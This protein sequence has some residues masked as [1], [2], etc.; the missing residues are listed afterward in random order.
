[1]KKVAIIG[2]CQ[3]RP[4]ANLL[5]AVVPDVKFVALTAV[6]RIDEHEVQNFLSSLDSFDV[7]ITQP[8]ATGYRKNIGIDTEKLRSRM[9]ANQRL[10]LIPNLYFEGFF[11]TWGYMK[12][13]QSNLRG[14]MPPGILPSRASEGIFATL[15]K[16]DYQCFFLLCAWLSGISAQTTAQYLEMKCD[17]DLV[18]SWSTDSLAE[19]AVRERICDTRMTLVLQDIVTHPEHWFY[20]FNHPNKALLVTLA[21]QLLSILEI[22][23]RNV[24]VMQSV[25]DLP[26]EL[27]NIQLPVYSFVSSSL[28][29]GERNVALRLYDSIFSPIEFVT[30]YFAYF[31]CLG[32]EGLAV[33][34]DNEKFEL[35]K[36]IISK[37]E[38]S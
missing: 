2:N 38:C 35:C 31:D 20:S 10:M 25:M 22:D 19:F 21:L 24:E 5:R 13:K 14:K 11:P 37:L 8:V 4:L 26:D 30:H 36:K 33:N 27:E 3:G 29:V 15:R 18:R 6:H 12:Y 1:M 9:R 28:G 17:F 23:K 7:V 32:Y 16:T 34:C